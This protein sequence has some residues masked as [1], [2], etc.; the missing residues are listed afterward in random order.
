MGIFNRIQ[1]KPDANGVVVND[2]VGVMLMFLLENQA[3]FSNTIKIVRVM[4]SR[5]G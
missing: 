1:N 4:M 3:K 2:V 5:Y